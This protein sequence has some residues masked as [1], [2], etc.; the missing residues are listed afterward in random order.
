MKMST[1]STEVS[2]DLDKGV[3]FSWGSASGQKQTSKT[4][5]KDKKGDDQSKAGGDAQAGADKDSE[6]KTA[7]DQCPEG[8]IF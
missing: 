6:K 4:G 5:D 2:A 1:G 3:Q 8:F 7:A